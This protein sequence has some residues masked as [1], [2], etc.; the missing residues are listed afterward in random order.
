MRGIGID[1]RCETLVG[2]ID[3]SALSL[4]HH[5]ADGLMTTRRKTPNAEMLPVPP[6]QAP[7]YPNSVYF[8]VG[9]AI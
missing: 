6:D 7:I 5:P 1:G 2:N 8:L 4:F 9:E 3:K